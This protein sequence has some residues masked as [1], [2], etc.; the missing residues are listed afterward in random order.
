RALEEVLPD[1]G[2]AVKGRVGE[3]VDDPELALE[4]DGLAR[5]ARALDRLGD[6]LEEVLLGAGAVLRH[7]AEGDRKLAPSLVLELGP[8]LAELR[9][10]E[11]HVELAQRP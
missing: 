10:L 1:V 3:V 7:P 2:I 5:G 11:D 6:L 4:L 9:L 8:A